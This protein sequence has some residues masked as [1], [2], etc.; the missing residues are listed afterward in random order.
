MTYMYARILLN[1]YTLTTQTLKSD[2][3]RESAKHEEEVQELVDKH[4]AEQMEIG[5]S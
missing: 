5:T 1:Y 3:E 4:N 2:K